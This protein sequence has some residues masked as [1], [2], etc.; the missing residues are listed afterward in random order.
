MKAIFKIICYNK[1]KDYILKKEEID[2]VHKY[3]YGENI[4]YTIMFDNGIKMDY[5]TSDK[6]EFIEDAM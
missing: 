5:V 6:L 2:I 1:N 4:Y 3:G